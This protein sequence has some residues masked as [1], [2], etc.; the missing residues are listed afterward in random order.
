MAGDTP[1]QAVTN[2]VRPLQDALACVTTAVI[3]R[4]GQYDLNQLYGLTLNGGEPVFIRR[5]SAPGRVG[6]RIGQQYR[7]V[8]AQGERGPYKVETRAYMYSVEDEAG[9][10]VFGYHWNPTSRVRT[11]HLHLEH[12]AQIGCAEIQAAHFPTGRISMEQFLRLVIDVYRLRTRRSDWR[13]ALRQSDEV[14]RRW[15]TWR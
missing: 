10:E 14:F 15:Q 9:H 7:I 2:Y 4:Q 5:A 3:E 13:S 12:G 11:P 1:R 8:E 6:I